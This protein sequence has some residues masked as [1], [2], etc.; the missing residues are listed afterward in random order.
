M[1]V[2]LREG[3]SF[4]SLLRRFNK[5]VMEGGVMKDLRRRRWFVPK[6]EQKRIDER[7]GRRRARMMRLRQEQE[8]G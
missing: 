6:G 8:E 1:T 4:D 3:E 2:K 7:K 5:E